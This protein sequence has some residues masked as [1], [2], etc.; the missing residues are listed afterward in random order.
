ME[1]SCE[2]G[3][4]GRPR[5]IARG[6]AI[7][8]ATLRGLV[9]VGYE[10]LSINEIAA[11]AHASKATLYRR[12]PAKSM[13]V[14][15]AVAY[16]LEKV[17]PLEAPNTNSLSGDITLIVSVVPDGNAFRDALAV[18]LDLSSVGI[19]DAELRS[20]I[21]LKILESRRRQ[22]EEVVVRAVARGELDTDKRLERIPD[23][24]LGLIMVHL[25]SDKYCGREEIRKLVEETIEPFRR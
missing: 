12:W 22:I 20:A 15:D 1:K 11:R 19:R 4:R 18:F 23:M 25:L 17:V 3:H 7:L 6:V 5:D 8:I 2:L 21:S 9:E 16:W 13:L 10:R 14:A 24:V